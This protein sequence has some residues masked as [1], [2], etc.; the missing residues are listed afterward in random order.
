MAKRR[1]SL[2]LSSLIIVLLGCA[3][4]RPLPSPSDFPLHAAEPPFGLHWRLDRDGSSVT[5]VGVIEVGAPDR[6]EAV[7]VELQGLDKDGRLLGR[8]RDTVLPRSFT[9]VEPW[10]FRTSLRA[11]GREDRFAV[12]VVDVTWKRQLMGG[13]GGR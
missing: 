10:P 5:A 11:T 4:P 6:I 8:S 7:T 3:A 9:G 1:A 13:A 2:V 12:T